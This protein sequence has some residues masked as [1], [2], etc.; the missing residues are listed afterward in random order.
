MLD[1]H[2]VTACMYF[3]IASKPDPKKKEKKIIIWQAYFETQ[4]RNTS[5]NHSGLLAA[6]FLDLNLTCSQELNVVV[7]LL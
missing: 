6:T 1:H 7:L 3:N 5:G 4:S 2:G